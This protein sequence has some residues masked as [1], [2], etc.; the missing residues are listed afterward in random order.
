MNLSWDSLL[1]EFLYVALFL[2]LKEEKE[3]K[4]THTHFQCSGKELADPECSEQQM[5]KLS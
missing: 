4:K 2:F 1:M 3:E 5:E